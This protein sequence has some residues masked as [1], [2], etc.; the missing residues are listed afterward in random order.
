MSLYLVPAIHQPPDKLAELHRFQSLPLLDA[1]SAIYPFR[2]K[3]VI[4]EMFPI[5]DPP[6]Q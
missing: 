5:F 2:F 1:P 4:S 3:I 6:P